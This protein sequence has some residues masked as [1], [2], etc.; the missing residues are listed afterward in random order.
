MA[1]PCC[2]WS[3]RLWCNS[4]LPWFLGSARRKGHRGV[5]QRLHIEPAAHTQSAFLWEVLV[6]SSMAGVCCQRAGST[7][8]C[9]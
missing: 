6:P 8:C 9:I 1:K 4:L 3:P 2:M 5:Q 7:R